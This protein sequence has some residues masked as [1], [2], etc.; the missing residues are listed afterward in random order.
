VTGGGRTNTWDSQDRLV[1]CTYNGTTTTDTYASDGLRHRMV[2]GTNTTDY[3]LDQTM[4][5]RELLN[6]TVKATVLVGHAVPSTVATTRPGRSAGTCTTAWAA[7]SGRW[8][9]TGR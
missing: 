3:V 7:W 8:R 9:R 2:V 6:G 4:Q 1:Q 5:V